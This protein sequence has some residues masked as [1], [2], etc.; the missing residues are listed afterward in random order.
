MS[1]K[2]FFF[3]LHSK[4]IALRLRGYVKGDFS[5]KGICKNLYAGVQWEWGMLRKKFSCPKA[6][7]WK[8]KYEAVEGNC[9]RSVKASP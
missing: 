4:V 7:I 1:T 5:S 2:V 8:E 9:H 6:K 3:H